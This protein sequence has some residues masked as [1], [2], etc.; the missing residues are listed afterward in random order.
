MKRSD[1]TGLF[2]DAT[3]EQIK[4]L[5]DINGADVNNARQGFKDLQSQLAEATATIEQ[6]QSGTEELA[7]TRERA[8]N[9]E[10]ELNGL[11]AANAIREVREKVSKATGIPVNLLTMDTEED[12]TTQANNIKEYTKPSAYPQVKDGGEPGGVVKPTPKQQFI[13]WFTENA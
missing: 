3:D 6:L 13:E 12:C 7:A 9:L 8:T 2:P 4:A 11:K 5:M 1:I 10:A